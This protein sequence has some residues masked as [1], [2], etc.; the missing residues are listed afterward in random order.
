[1]S[2]HKLIVYCRKER[3]FENNANFDS[4]SKNV[5]I[6]S[7]FIY[8]LQPIFVQLPIVKQFWIQRELSPC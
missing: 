7:Y 2:V 3:A 5:T 1:M 6:M 8:Q 4:L